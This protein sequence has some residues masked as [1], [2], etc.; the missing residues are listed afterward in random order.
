MPII[1]RTFLASTFIILCM[2]NNVTANEVCDWVT[3]K[4]LELRELKVESNFPESALKRFSASMVSS[5][6]SENFLKKGQIEGALEGFIELFFDPETVFLVDGT[7]SEEES[8]AIFYESCVEATF[9]GVK[10]FP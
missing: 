9:L 2:S 1:N 6:R 7:F 10:L 4:T 8:S 5:E 3:E